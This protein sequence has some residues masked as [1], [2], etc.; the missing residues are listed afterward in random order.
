M[1]QILFYACCLFAAIS[2]SQNAK[3]DSLTVRL[4]Y[5]NQDSTK[6]ET[7]LLL[8]NELY[9]IKDYNKALLFVDQTSELS[10][11]LDYKKG[12]AE[13]YFIKA[14]INTDKS[15]PNKAIN[16]FGHQDNLQPNLL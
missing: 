5:Q 16:N 4:A 14:L 2:F 10:K 8:I 11:S 3:I 6:V 12:L 7:S 1:K 9:N 13:T 15:E